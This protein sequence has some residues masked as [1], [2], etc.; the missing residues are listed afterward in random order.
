MNHGWDCLHQ[1]MNEEPGWVI[2]VGVGTN[3]PAPKICQTMFQHV[4]NSSI[5][6]K[7]LL[8]G[9]CGSE[10][11]VP[12]RQIWTLNRSQFDVNWEPVSAPLMGNVG[13]S[14]ARVTCS[15]FPRSTELQSLCFTHFYIYNLFLFF[16]G[17]GSFITDA[18][19]NQLHISQS[20][21][22]K[23]IEVKLLC[24]I[25][26]SACLVWKLF[27]IS[28]SRDSKASSP[29]KKSSYLVCK[30]MLGFTFNLALVSIQS[31]LWCGLGR[32]RA[33]HLLWSLDRLQVKQIPCWSAIHHRHTHT[34]PHNAHN[35]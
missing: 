18:K 31:S 30:A 32:P 16:V 6:V 3:Y 5:N 25:L 28:S 9:K 26:W 20:I 24:C 19:L 21:L 13:T 10:H 11:S 2:G 15:D 8:C 7:K 1:K 17:C 35:V 29:Q 27:F 23:K 33:N 4:R 12:S 14:L 34:H 22:L